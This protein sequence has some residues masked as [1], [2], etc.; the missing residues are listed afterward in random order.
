MNRLAAPAHAPPG[1]H[2]I[3]DIE[4]LRAIAVGLVIFH[5][6]R[7]I[8]LTWPDRNLDWLARHFNFATGVNIFFGISG[9]VIARSLLPAL[10]KTP[11]AG[12][13]A[14]ETGAFWVRR[15]WR[16]L[17]SAWLAKP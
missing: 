11:S 6:A 10:L 13:Y 3:D 5:H 4:I 7:D 17:P 1:H 8:L 9:F 2:R 16:L 15:A 14:L 12:A